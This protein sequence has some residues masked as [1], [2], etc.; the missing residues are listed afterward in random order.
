[1]SGNRNAMLDPRKY[2]GSFDSLCDSKADMPSCHCFEMQLPI[3]PKSKVCID[4]FF[5]SANGI[6][7]SDQYGRVKVQSRIEAIYR[8]NILGL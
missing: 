2:V 4:F 1:M 3:F 6:F 7:I 5:V 8:R